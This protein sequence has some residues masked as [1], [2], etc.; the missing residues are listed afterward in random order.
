[1]TKDAPA[2]HVVE[3]LG[4][5]CQKCLYVESVIREVVER[6]GLAVEIRHL[7]DYREIAARGVMST[8][9]I[10]VDGTVVLAGRVPT[11]GQVAAWLGIE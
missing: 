7:T 2:V 10:A 1:M 5:G 3:V 4:P 9:A 8:P 11:R 6:A